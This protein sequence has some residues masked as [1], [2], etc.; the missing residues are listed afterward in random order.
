MYP[1]RRRL[2]IGY[3]QREVVSAANGQWKGRFT[4][5][6]ESILAVRPIRA[7]MRPTAVGTGRRARCFDDGRSDEVV[8]SRLQ[9]LSARAEQTKRSKALLSLIT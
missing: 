5:G 1:A 2:P 4:N 7:R 6:R 8:R 3:R 9:A